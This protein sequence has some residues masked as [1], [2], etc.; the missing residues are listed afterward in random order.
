[1][2]ARIPDRQ[3]AAAAEGPE[4]G[5]VKGAYRG[6]S[7]PEM[8]F[9]HLLALEHVASD[10][11]SARVAAVLP[12]LRM[13]TAPLIRSEDDLQKRKQQATKTRSSAR[14]KPEVSKAKERVGAQ[15]EAVQGAHSSAVD[16]LKRLDERW[17]KEP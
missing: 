14:F 12:D 2:I 16:E 10:A 13:Q 11:R 5:E 9:Q 3:T 17:E 8:G 1:M 15:L 7:N 4:L 6:I